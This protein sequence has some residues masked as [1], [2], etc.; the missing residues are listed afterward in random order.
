MVLVN[1]NITTMAEKSNTMV[2]VTKTT[3]GGE[4]IL[5][6]FT[7]DRKPQ[8]PPIVSSYND[9]IRPILD[10]V[11]KLRRLKVTQEGIPLPAIVVVGDQS[12]GKS[13]VLESLA[14]I[15]LPRGQNICTR[16]PLIMRLQNHPDAV[17]ELILEYQKKTV[18][19]MEERQISDAIDK[20][21]V[22]IAGDNKGISNVPLTLVVKK[23]GVPNLTMIDLPGI[24]RVAV[25][26]QPE[27]IYEQISDMIM[28]HI[29]PEESIIL[30]VLDANVDF[31]TC[32]SICMSRRVDSTGQRTLA[33]VTKSDQSPEGLHEKVMSNDV[34]IG[35]GYICVRNRIKDETY[36]EAR[37]QEAT[38][39]QTH[40]LLSKMDK[41]IVG[42]PV[43]AHTLVQIQSMIIS[44][45]LPDI[46]K[47]IH[48]R[49]NASVLELNKLPRI[50]TSIPDAMAAFMQIVG[51]LKET[52]QK[53]LIRGELEYDDKEMHCNARLAEML[54]EFSEELHKSEKISENFLVEEMLVLEEANGIRLSFFLSHS[55]FLY[56]LKKKLTNI[57]NLPISF[58]NKVWGYL[59]IVWVRVLMDHCENHPQILPSMKKA[60][61]NVMLRMKEKLVERVY[62]K[63]ER[64]KVTDYTCDP[65]F[66]ASWNKLMGKRDEFLRAVPN[67]NSFS[68]EGY[69][70]IDI[71]HLVSVPA[72]KRDQAFD[73]KM[74]IMAYWKIVSRR[75]VDWIALELRFVIQKMVNKVMEKEIVNEVMMRGGGGGMEKMLDEPTPVAAKRERLQMSIGLLQESQQIIQQVMDAI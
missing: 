35:L 74:R 46:V 2:P 68:M 42:I 55:A 3:N 49:L 57:S 48:E 14:G 6:P 15:S 39:F 33:V 28:E 66:I 26:D 75:I 62:K 16:V 18:M 52:F 11:D 41:S 25:G 31:S 50:L 30:N 53:I 17:P 72:T 69:G 65:D 43:L 20:A 27:N 44:K 51:S 64:E 38:L 58:L 19:I 22:E 47:K 12:S 4:V 23:N 9:K 34:N 1:N 54:D 67:R 61:L 29:K 40:P 24:A 45:C 60:S 63:I 8:F 37:M 71:T 36:E 56:L 13:S 7:E 10:A 21:T 32:E 73:L 5:P 59:E 70:S